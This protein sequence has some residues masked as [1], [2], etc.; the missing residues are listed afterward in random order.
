MNAASTALHAW[1]CRNAA[2]NLKPARYGKISASRTAS[3][4]RSN[5]L[6]VHAL[7]RGAQPAAPCS[8][9][10]SIGVATSAF[11]QSTVAPSCASAT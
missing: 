8:I 4:A 1:R 7:S 6:A 3:G 11:D 2:T 10:L 5:G 9:I